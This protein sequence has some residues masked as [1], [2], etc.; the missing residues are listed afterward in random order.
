[1]EDRRGEMCME[2]RRGSW[3]WDRM[4]SGLSACQLQIPE[5]KKSYIYEWNLKMLEGWII[6]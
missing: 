6:L 3:G 5:R 2:G 4:R 1:M